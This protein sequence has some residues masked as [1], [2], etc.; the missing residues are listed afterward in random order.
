M[1]PAPA[2][3][4]PHGHSAPGVV[5]HCFESI[6]NSKRSHPSPFILCEPLAASIC[7]NFSHQFFCR[8]FY[9]PD[10]AKCI[11][12]PQVPP[13]TVCSLVVS[14]AA[15]R[16]GTCGRNIHLVKCVPEKT[17]HQGK[18]KKRANLPNNLSKFEQICSRKGANLVQI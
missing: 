15:L 4:R 11:F 16:R 7:S 3:F 13:L 2:L 9:L 18:S 14:E 17:R 6:L 5:T 10:L 1:V 8:P 12:R